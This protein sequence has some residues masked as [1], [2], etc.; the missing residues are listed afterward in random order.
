MYQ[1]WHN[2]PFSQ[3]NKTKERAVGVGDGDNREG[4]RGWTKFEKGE[5]V[6][7]IGGGGIHKIRGVRTPLLTIIL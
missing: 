1:I 2:H 3:R 7:N 6:G 4:W 5:G